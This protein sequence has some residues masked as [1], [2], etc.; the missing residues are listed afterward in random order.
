MSS[1][2][3]GGLLQLFGVEYTGQHNRYSSLK[4]LPPYWLMFIFLGLISEENRSKHIN[5]VRSLKS[6]V[7]Q[8]PPAAPSTSRRGQPS[9][10]PPAAV[11][12]AR[13]PCNKALYCSSCATCSS[14][15]D[16]LCRCPK[17][18]SL[19][20]RPVFIGCTYFQRDFYKKENKAI[21]KRR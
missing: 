21:V 4:L 17:G 15:S 3:G 5:S 10:L 1:A 12:R 7:W 20:N 9:L 8:T 16:R 18:I 19:C 14:K 13:G 6:S 11:E 2:G